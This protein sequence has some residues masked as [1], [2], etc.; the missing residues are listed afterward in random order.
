MKIQRYSRT[1]KKRKKRAKIGRI[2]PNVNVPQSKQGEQMK[3]FEPEYYPYFFKT[4]DGF[5]CCITDRNSLIQISGTQAKNS[6]LIENFQSR[7]KVL[8]IFK[9]PKTEIAAEEFRNHMQQKFLSFW[10]SV[11][12][13]KNAKM[14]IT[15]KIQKK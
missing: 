3:A 9:R 8:K 11:P 7:Q 6:F 13:I 15:S 5:Y 4:S 1:G 12:G 10:N 14:L 2:L